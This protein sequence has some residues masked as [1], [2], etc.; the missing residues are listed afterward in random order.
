[1]H[2]RVEA[3]GLLHRGVEVLPAVGRE[4]VPAKLQAGVH[5]LH[6]ALAQDVV[7]HRLVFLNRDGARRVHDVPAR[8]GARVAAVDGRHQQLLLQ[9][10]A[11]RDVRLGLGHLHGAVLGDDARPRARRVEQHAVDVAE[12]LRQ[13]SSVVVAHGRVGAPHP[14]QVR[15]QGRQTFLLELVREDHARVAHER[16]QVGGFPAGRRRDVEHALALLRRQSHARQERRRA[17]Q[18][19]VA[20]HVLRRRAD[21]HA[22]VVHQ[23]PHLG[24]LADGV[25]VHAA[26]D[27]RRGEFAATAFQRVRAK[28]HRPLRLVRLEKLHGL[29]HGE[30][31]EEVPDQEVVVPVV[32]REVRREPLDVLA[33][34]TA[35]LAPRLEVPEHPDNLLDPRL[36]VFQVGRRVRVIV[37]LLQLVH[38]LLLDVGLQLLGGRV[39]LLFFQARVF[40]AR[41]L[42]DGQQLLGF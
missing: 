13:R 3:S 2:V 19:V 27:E 40:L 1:M 18:H 17:L 34:G 6:V 25:E 38:V 30:S 9:V 15:D 21:G 4:P 5:Q 8:L 12:N 10:R 7:Q 37:R 39:R 16:R 36:H 24:P 20:R 14:L 41:L 32:R 29:R 28:R 35:S 26:V 11:L 22:A 31:V 33:P 42:L 23:Q